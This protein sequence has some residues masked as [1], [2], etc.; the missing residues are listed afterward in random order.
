MSNT[1]MIPRA[2]L[3]LATDGTNSSENK[4][5]HLSLDRHAG[6]SLSL[7]ELRREVHAHIF[8]TVAYIRMLIALEDAI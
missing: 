3:R 7:A 6:A 5:S 1:V 4:C 2:S 8:E